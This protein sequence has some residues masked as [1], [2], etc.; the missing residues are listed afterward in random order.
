MVSR[1]G[2]PVILSAFILLAIAFSVIV[3]LGEAPDEVPHFAYV[4]YLATQK[5]LPESKGEALG[6]VHQPPLYY[7]LGA[8]VTAPIPRAG[9][10]VIANP[11]FVLN[12]PKT[13]NLLLH[14]DEAFPYRDDVL[15]WHLVRLLSVAMGAVIVWATGKIAREIFPSDSWIVWGSAAF[16]AFLPGFIF[17]SAAVNNDNL[18]V[19]LSSLCVL[20]VVRST[21]RSFPI[22]DA[23][24]L[25]ILLGLAA[26]SKLTGFVA[27]AFAAANW[28]FVACTSRDWKHPAKSFAVCFGVAAAIVLPWLIY[29]QLSYGDPLGWSVYLTVATARSDPMTFGSWARLGLGLFTSFWGRFGGALQ[30]YMPAPIYAALAI[31]GLLP[32]AGWV[33]YASDV[34]EGKK[35]F[36]FRSLLFFFALFGLLMLAVYVRWALGDLAAGQARLIFPWLPLIAIFFT[37][38]LARLF[39][40]RAKIAIVIFSSVL[41]AIDLAGLGWLWAI[42]NIR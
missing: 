37:A 38:G 42:Y 22:G 32:L 33:R 41:A 31:A 10:H 26:M 20:Q 13:P 1:L 11:D 8:L 9:F 39:G 18:V 4:Q 29:N 12:D 27:W 24:I 5:K 17:I 35:D 28:L 19:M 25:G 16:V 3:P 30:I 40:A 23:I 21:R 36:D 2:L 15:A 6:E 14:K 7:F 34:R